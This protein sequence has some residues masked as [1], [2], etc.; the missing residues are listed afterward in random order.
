MII[1]RWL[2]EYPGAEHEIDV[3]KIA[4]PYP[5]IEFPQIAPPVE[6][7]YDSEPGLHL[8]QMSMTPDK[9]NVGIGMYGDFGRYV[10][11]SRVED[12]IGADIEQCYNYAIDFIKNKLG[13]EEKTLGFYDTHE[14]RSASRSDN[15][16]LERIGKKYE[17]IAYFNILARLSDKY[18]IESYE[19]GQSTSYEGPWNPMIRDFDPTLNVHF[20][21]STNDPIFD[22]AEM[23]SG[24]IDST[25]MTI[26]KLSQW[27]GIEPECIQKHGNAL[28]VKDN[29]G[30]PWIYLM[31]RE[32]Y[33]NEIYQSQYKTGFSEGGQSLWIE[34]YACVVEKKNAAAFLQILQQAN[35][36]GRWMT[37]FSKEYPLFNM[38][39][40]WSNGY[41]SIFGDPWHVLELPS[42]SGLDTDVAT[43]LGKYAPLTSR[44]IWEG[45]YDGSIDDAISICMPNGLLIEGLS[46]HQKEYNGHFY[47][48]N[49]ELIIIDGRTAGCAEGLLIREDA[50]NEFLNTNDY[51]LFWPTLA[52]KLY[53]T[54]LSRNEYVQSE[55][56]GLYH[57][58]NGEI[59]GSMRCVGIYPRD[60][61]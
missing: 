40:A 18:S 26:E 52:N 21:S 58:E 61:R 45:E 54:A 22:K 55:W 44:Y 51:V 34:S 7:S 12:F 39:Y 33:E 14:R 37:V 59:K 36:W 60:M 29:H 56:S 5:A 35:F 23:C 41:K 3:N 50:L 11:Q 9:A 24:F 42:E 47:N 10:F 20:F 17:W 32:D 16:K 1:E 28:K 49:N 2:F 48:D 38:E 25:D 19:Y 53:K 43:S 13:Y 27:V 31:H 30:T 15:K 57:Y 4:P 8:I 6:A 46:L